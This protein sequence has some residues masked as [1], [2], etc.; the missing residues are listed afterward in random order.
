M[1]GIALIGCVAEPDYTGRICSA[2]APCPSGFVCLEDRCAAAGLGPAPDAGFAPDARVS[3]DAEVA[4]DATVDAGV[5]PVD[6]GAPVDAG[7]EPD[8]GPRLVRIM[9]TPPSA[10]AAAG[11]P[12]MFMAEAEDDLGARRDVTGEASWRTDDAAV[13][14]CLGGLCTGLSPGAVLVEAELDGVIGQAMLTVTPAVPVEVSTF[15]KHSLVRLSDGRAFAWGWNEH[16]QVED[17]VFD[18]IE[19]ATQVDLTQVVRV[20]AGGVHSVAMRADGSVWAW[21]A[22]A[23]GQLGRGTVGGRDDG[24][25]APVVGIGGVGTLSGVDD[26]ACGYDFCLALLAGEVL[27]WGGDTFGTLGQGGG[28]NAAR[29]VPTRVPGLTNVVEVAAGTYHAVARTSNGEIWTWGYDE[30]GQLGH[31]TVNQNTNVPAPVVGTDGTGRLSG[32]VEIDA[33]WGHTLART[34]NGEVLAWGWTAFRQL[35]PG[36]TADSGVPDYI[37]TASQARLTGVSQL[38]AGFA[39]GLVRTQADELLSW[40]NNTFGQLGAGLMDPNRAAPGPVLDRLGGTPFTRAQGFSAGGDHAVAIVGDT[41]WAWGS[42]VF[43]ELGNGTSGAGEQSLVP[44]VV[45]IPR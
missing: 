8:A 3:P 34:A 11:E 1:V 12:T 26:L 29:G 33:G 42:N 44:V 14:R 15:N 16:R 36:R 7:V 2:E 21:G 37:V 30:Y 24:D 19:E 13:A 39:F 17:S 23:A 9:V 45:P 32:I 6:A 31:G 4:V 10:I 20:E 18:E 25:P 43:G 5:P 41:V 22:D 35:G 40:G 27:A 28:T 38:S